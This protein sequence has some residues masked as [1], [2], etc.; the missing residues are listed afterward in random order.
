MGTLQFTMAI[1]PKSHPTPELPPL[2]RAPAGEAARHGP[3]ETSMSRPGWTT[4]AIPREL[5]AEITKL[6][7]PKKAK[8]VQA[9]IIFWAK[10][11]SLIDRALAASSDPAQ[12]MA[13]LKAGIQSPEPDEE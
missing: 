7:I 11:G 6:H 8:S 5:H 1:G 3:G 13:A 9:Y 2:A 10:A 12:L 4:I